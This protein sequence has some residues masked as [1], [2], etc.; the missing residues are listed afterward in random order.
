MSEII[1]IDDFLSNKKFNEEV[2]PFFK[3]LNPSFKHYNEKYEKAF[4]LNTGINV[5]VFV[6]YIPRNS[7]TDLP[8]IEESFN[9]VKNNPRNSRGEWVVCNIYE[10]PVDK[11]YDIL[12]NINET[13]EPVNYLKE[14]IAK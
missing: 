4:V 7:F 13:N 3:R 6:K 2:L 10:L 9:D 1:N 11:L 14:K 8:T 5:V 12:K